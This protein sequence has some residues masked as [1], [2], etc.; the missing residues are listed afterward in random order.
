M[1][2]TVAEK[3]FVCKLANLYKDQ[4]ITD[5]INDIRYSCKDKERATIEMVRAARYQKGIKREHGSG[6]VKKR[7]S[8]ED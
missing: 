6:R 4:E 2:L 3:E 5:K 7:P 1:A 8:R